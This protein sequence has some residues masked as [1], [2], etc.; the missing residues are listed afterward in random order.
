M[1]KNKLITL[2]A[3]NDEKILDEIK[4]IEKI[5]IINSDI[6]YIEG[7]FEF[8]EINKNIDLIILKEDI[9]KNIEIIKLIE[10]I[11]LINKKIKI[12]IL[13]SN[14]NLEK[15]KI[16]KEN[17]INYFYI[18]NNNIK[19]IINIIE[20]RKIKNTA[21]KI[22][23]VGNAGNGKT[24]FTIILAEILRKIFN[25][26]I[27]LIDGDIKHNSLTK[28]YLNTNKLNEINNINNNLTII[29]I[30]NIINNKKSII[31]EIK[32]QENKF[33]YIIFDIKKI[34]DIKFYKKI[35]NQFILIL[36]LNLLEIN[37]ILKIINQNKNIKIILNNYNKNCLS[38]KITAKIFDNKKIIEKIENN[39]NYNLIINNNLNINLLDKKTKSKFINIIKK[40]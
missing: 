9:L 1:E 35:I 10:K 36:E 40:I 37:K 14:H 18:K 20:N 29:N 22:G 6:Q 24:I 8:L 34:E 32:K 38:E 21:Q 4:N 15:E 13:L 12:I 27:L 26:K 30:K 2:T 23:V 31:K 5:K 39:E 3:I 25:K 11:K 17:K 33:D 7:I 28:L 19:N 16:F